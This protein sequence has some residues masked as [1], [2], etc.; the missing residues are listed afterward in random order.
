[1]IAVVIVVIIAIIQI[2]YVSRKIAAKMKQVSAD[3]M[4]NWTAMAHMLDNF[5]ND[6]S[7]E[8]K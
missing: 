7:A 2:T 8:K 1:M 3:Y 4:C 5:S 6:L